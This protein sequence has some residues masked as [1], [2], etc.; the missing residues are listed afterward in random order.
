MEQWD[1]AALTDGVKGF[2][3]ALPAPLVTPEA[4]A[5]AHRALRGESG[6]NPG[7]GRALGRAGAGPG[8]PSPGRLSAE[9]AGPVGPALEPPTL[10]LHSALTLRFLL[11]HLGRV[12]RRAPALGSAVRALSAAFGPLLLRAPSPSPPPGG[13]PDG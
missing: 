8:S 6:R 11:Q 10:P 12:A 9:A 4:A 5:E 3:L 13:A 2:L 7:L 1:A